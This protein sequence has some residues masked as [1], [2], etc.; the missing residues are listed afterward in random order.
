MDQDHVFEND[1]HCVFDPAV[2]TFGDDAEH[3]QRP[4]DAADEMIGR[5]DEGGGNQHVP[6]LVKRQKGQRAEDMKV[7]FD[8]AARQVDEERGPQ[9][10]RD[11]NDMAR[12]R[13]ARH[14]LRE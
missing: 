11:G 8:S 10:L 2:V 3:G 9:H 1:P 5:D 12:E 13:G 6:I 7:G 14:H 4:P